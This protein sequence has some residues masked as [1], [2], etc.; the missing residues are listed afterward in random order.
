V[1]YVS[2]EIDLEDWVV[3]ALIEDGFWARR[4]NQHMKG[5]Y[6]TD[7]GKREWRRLCATQVFKDARFN[8]CPV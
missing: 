4:G 8:R 5:L 2:I 7:K 6:L 3:D 1:K